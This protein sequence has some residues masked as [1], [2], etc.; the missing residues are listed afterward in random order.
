[1]IRAAI[2][3]LLTCTATATAAP[4]VVSQ[5][6]A[7]SDVH[8]V[9]VLGGRLA[10]A[11]SGG[12]VIRRG[13]RSR[14]LTAVDGM[15]GVRLR[16]VSAINGALWVGGIDGAARLAADREG[17]LRVTHRIALRRVR[18][19]VTWRGSIWLAT[20]GGGLYTLPANEPGAAPRRVKLGRFRSRLTD[21]VIAGDHL[22]V[23]TAGAGIVVINRRGTVDRLIDRRH[24]LGSNIVWDLAPSGGDVLVATSAGVYRAD[25]SGS[26][27]RRAPITRASR[28]IPIRDARAVLAAGGDRVWVA[29]HGAG[30]WRV[31]GARRRRIASN[32]VA[33]ALASA[34]DSVLV[35]SDRGASEIARGGD[36]ARE[37]FGG[38]LP[39]ADVTALARAFDRIWVGTF[40]GGLASMDRRGRVK[41]ERRAGERW[42]LDRRINDLAVTRDRR[43]RERLWIATDRGLWWH[44]GRQLSREIDLHA[45]GR[46]HVTSLHVD[47]SGALWATSART[48]ARRAAGPTGRWRSWTGD[49]HQ[50]MLQ[51]HAVTTGL[52]GNVWVGTL[53][54]LVRLDPG[55]GE[56]E[57]HSVASAELPVDWVT[58][59]IP[60]DGGV[61]AGT[62]HG[63]L[64]WI[65]DGRFRVEREADGGLPAGWVNPHAMEVVDGALWIGTLDRGLMIGKT[66]AWRL[67]RITDGLP[68][69]DV[70][71][72]LAD[73]PD[74]VWVATR[75]GLARLRTLGAAPPT[76]PKVFSPRSK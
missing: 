25:T 21:L 40:A 8:D 66:G 11:T 74:H 62:Y 3:A 32:Q 51:A 49:D 71:A 46:V 61:V 5:I 64:S 20:F 22:W 6:T 17:R 44:D 26:I 53:H 56:L 63:G 10:F 36:R 52:D 76:A 47:A 18:R 54:G 9:A 48:V 16:S 28:R 24:G 4:R 35:A 72:V 31:D 43:G 33:R 73:G 34:G 57:H 60:F 45:P 58:A 19:A 27:A 70:T 14:T 68:S 41:A 55:S 23:A 75:G 15:P 1:M 7:T 65:R 67:L 37:L 69:N 13:D 29:T 30:V 50:P 2:A 59:L 38:G 12:L 39:S 42:G